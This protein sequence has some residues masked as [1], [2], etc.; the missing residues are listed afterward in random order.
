ME[1]FMQLKTY[2]EFVEKIS[3]SNSFN[4]KS[5]EDA[6]KVLNCLLYISQNFNHI[7]AAVLHR[8]TKGTFD[9]RYYKDYRDFQHGVLRDRYDTSFHYSAFI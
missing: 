8:N 9:R 4:Q 6:L 7:R 1:N 5:K 3:V 2:V